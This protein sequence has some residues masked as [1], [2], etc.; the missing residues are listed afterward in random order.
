MAK[1]C[2]GSGAELRL[3]VGRSVA[4]TLLVGF[5]AGR[6]TPGPLWEYFGN[7]AAAMWLN[8]LE[9]GVGLAYVFSFA[10]V[11]LQPYVLFDYRARWLGDFE[12]SNCAGGLLGLI[13]RGKLTE[14]FGGYVDLSWRVGTGGPSFR[15][16][17][18]LGG[19]GPRLGAG[20][21]L[22]FL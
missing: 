11:D 21:S 7:G 8:E 6:T 13:V 17:E 4:A 10:P 19:H 5:A 2:S 12:M 22:M 9:L 18:I 20:L 1:R 16:V 14:N 3:T 15:D